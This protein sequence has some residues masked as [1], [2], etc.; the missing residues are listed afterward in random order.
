M[1]RK[2]PRSLIPC[3]CGCGASVL[4]RDVKGMPRRYASPACQLRAF[5]TLPEY[6]EARRIREARATTAR[7]LR[8]HARAVEK[9]GPEALA[10]ER[11]YRSGYQ[12]AMA[13]WR[14]KYLRA[15]AAKVAS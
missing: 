6:A 5:W 3:H 10:Y 2:I 8:A 7:R 13:W 9:A 4:N 14:R 15:L 1:S 12:R 11:G